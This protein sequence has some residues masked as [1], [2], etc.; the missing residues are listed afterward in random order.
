MEQRQYHLEPNVNFDLSFNEVGN[1]D[2]QSD[3]PVHAQLVPG[4]YATR[5]KFLLLE[6]DST[7]TICLSSDKLSELT[8]EITKEKRARVYSSKRDHKHKF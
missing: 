5:R 2:E 6:T 7:T 1:V 3:G 4:R 8:V